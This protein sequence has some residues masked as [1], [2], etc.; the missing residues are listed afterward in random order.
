MGRGTGSIGSLSD[1]RELLGL[2]RTRNL[3]RLRLP[4]TEG[5]RGNRGQGRRICTPNVREP[6][7]PLPESTIRD[8]VASLVGGLTGADGG[9]RW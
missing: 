5:R 2:L 7:S 1:Y 8:K 3:D 6:I 9:G 4:S